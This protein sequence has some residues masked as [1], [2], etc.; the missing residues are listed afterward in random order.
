MGHLPWGGGIVKLALGQLNGMPEPTYV[1]KTH[2]EGKEQGSDH[3]PDH[4]KGDV[5]DNGI[6]IGVG[7]N[8]RGIVLDHGKVVRAPFDH[9]GHVPGIVDYLAFLQFVL[10]IP[11]CRRKNG[12]LPIPASGDHRNGIPFIEV[13]PIGGQ[14]L[15][16]VILSLG[17]IGPAWNADLLDIGI[18]HGVV[19]PNGGKRVPKKN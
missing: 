7:K 11:R 19:Y 5:L 4:N 10:Q 16:E 6:S 15:L 1:D 12:H 14:P 9:M 2:S 18:G 13:F 8:D 17:L 3:Q